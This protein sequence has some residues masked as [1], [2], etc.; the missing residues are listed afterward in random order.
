VESVV[1]VALA[2]RLLVIALDALAQGLPTRL[3]RKRE[4]GGVAARRRAAGAALEPVRHDDPRTHGLIEMDMAVDSAG[5]D[6]QARSVD[7][8]SGARQV[9]RQGDDTAVLDAHIAFAHVGG[10]DHRST[11][12][13]QIKLHSHY[14]LLSPA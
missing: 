6:Q 4:D 1:D 2:L 14:P 3:Q 7:L 8:G 11:A 5:Q 10:G 12:N 13:D 9:L